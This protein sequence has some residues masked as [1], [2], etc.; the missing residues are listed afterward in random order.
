MR[1]AWWIAPALA[2]AAAV[3]LHAQGVGCLFRQR[4]GFACAGCG[5]TRAL[6]ALARGEVALAWHLHPLALPFAIEVS[7]LW[8]WIGW[9]L[10]RRRPVP[11]RVLVALGL[12]DLAALLV[13]WL[14]RI[15]R[16]TLPP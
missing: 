6:A 16:G 2:G 5:M 8:I 9:R 1:A 13:V 12:A 14:W 3:W 11:G 15:G 4:F 10:G 7:G